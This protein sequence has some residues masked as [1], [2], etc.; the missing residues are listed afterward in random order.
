M[1]V[2]VSVEVDEYG[3]VI[4]DQKLGEVND[5]TQLSRTIPARQ[6][7]P[8]KPGQADGVASGGA[9]SVMGIWPRQP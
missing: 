8:V 3:V 2:I 7:L 1:L 9:K 5:E 4:L 6:D